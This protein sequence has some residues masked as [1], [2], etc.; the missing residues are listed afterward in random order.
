[1]Q[2][3]AVETPTVYGARTATQEASCATSSLYGDDGDCYR[4]RD[5]L[6][7]QVLFS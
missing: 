7:S 2:E 3:D 6:S 5:D 4:K 1:M